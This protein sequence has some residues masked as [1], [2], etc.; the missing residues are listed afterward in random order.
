[1]G[2]AGQLPG[3]LWHRSW[4]VT[5]VAGQHPHLLA[6]SEGGGPRALQVKHLF[7]LHNFTSEPARSCQ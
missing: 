4:N 5:P 7:L 3:S 2:P 1:M 6:R